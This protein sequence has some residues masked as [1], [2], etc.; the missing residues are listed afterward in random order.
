MKVRR[1][2][3]LTALVSAMLGALAGYLVLTVPNDLQAGTLLKQAR[4]DIAAGKTSDAHDALTQIIQRYPRTDAAAAATV[5]LV[6]LEEQQ[7]ERMQA[8]IVKL[9]ESNTEQAK[10]IGDLQKSVETIRKAPPPQAQPAA[11]QPPAAKTPA[12]KVTTKKTPTKKPPAKKTKK[13]R[14]R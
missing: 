12:K 11:V 2:L 13:R 14:K 10:A 7:R 6:K 3:I 5:A 8:E 4:S 9:R 1:L